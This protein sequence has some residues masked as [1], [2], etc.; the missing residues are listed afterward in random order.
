MLE[1]KAL[2]K[3]LISVSPRELRFDGAK[4]KTIERTVRIRAAIERP[5]ILQVV[6]FSLQNELTYRLK[7]V[8][9]GRAFNVTFK[10]VPGRKDRFRGFL[11]LKTNYA[12]KPYVIIYLQG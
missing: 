2:V 4:G 8:E 12:E 6:E 7:E 3:P 9:R 1:V 5:L 10:G 11:K